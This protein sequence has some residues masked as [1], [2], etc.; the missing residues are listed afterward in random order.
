[1]LPTLAQPIDFNAALEAAHTNDL[2][3]IPWTGEQANT[4][5][6]VL[7]HASRNESH[8]VRDIALFL[9]PEGGFSA[10]EIEAAQSANVTPITLGPRILRAETAA[11]VATTL[12]LNETGEMQL[13][14]K[15]KGETEV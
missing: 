15:S 14:N 13:S 2:A 7:A 5:A 11:I 9:G 8:P 6:S 1:M 3:M 4:I 12:T 10:S